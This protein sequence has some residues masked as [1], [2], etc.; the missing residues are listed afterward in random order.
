[1]QE[2][3]VRPL[4]VESPLWHWQQIDRQVVDEP[5]PGTE[6]PGRPPTRA[7]GVPHRVRALPAPRRHLT[8]V[9]SMTA[10]ATHRTVGFVGRMTEKGRSG[11]IDDGPRH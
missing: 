9:G 4:T 5:R 10:I 6:P 7:P 8:G 3:I 1:M 11:T 2:S